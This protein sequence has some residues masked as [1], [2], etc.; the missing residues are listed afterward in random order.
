MAKIIISS[1]ST[2]DLSPEL[3]EKYNVSIIPLGITLGDKVY[4]DGI[5]ITPD[6]VYAHH[7]KTGELPKTTA[8][9]VGEFIDYFTDLTKDG[10]AVIHFTISSSMS[11][12]YSN[13]CLAAD[14]FDNVYVVD[15]LNL[16]TG[17][18]LQ[19]LAAAEMAQNGMEPSDIV[20]ELEK[21]TPC[22]DASFVIDSLEYLHKGGRCSA[23]AMLGANLLKLKPCIEVKGGAMGVGKKYRGA[24]GR[25][26]SEYVDERLQ[27]VDSLVTKRVFVTHAGCDPEVVD[28]VVEQVKS[29][30]IF[31]EV[32]VT[33][34]GCTISSHCGANTLGVLFIRKSPIA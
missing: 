25:V 28:A 6:D 30:G 32:L 4:R 1:D 15:S 16:S 21:I 31:E 12:T 18:G 26:L 19:V 13:A 27:D 20:A 3:V 7:D 23:V 29:K 33:R 22:V 11:S 24:Y 2:C 8:A 5:D 10:D 9:N 14:D 17:G 34:A